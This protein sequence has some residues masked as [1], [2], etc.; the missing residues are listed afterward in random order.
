MSNLNPKPQNKPVSA[1]LNNIDTQINQVITQVKSGKGLDT[2]NLSS[3][4]GNIQQLLQQANLPANIKEALQTSLNVIHTSVESGKVDM[5]SLFKA[6]M[7]IKK[8]LR[9]QKPE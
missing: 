5:P 4:E 1:Q 3:I 2:S 9:S 6:G 7:D 8:A